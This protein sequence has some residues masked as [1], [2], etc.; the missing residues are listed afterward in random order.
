MLPYIVAMSSK[1]GVSVA[2]QDGVLPQNKQQKRSCNQTEDCGERTVN[3]P[4]FPALEF[5]TSTCCKSRRTS[6]PDS[7]ISR[8]ACKTI[9]RPGSQNPAASIF[10]LF[11]TFL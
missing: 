4:P 9:Q 5:N 10:S 1:A 8:A 3:S 11:P 7:W 2:D 6:I